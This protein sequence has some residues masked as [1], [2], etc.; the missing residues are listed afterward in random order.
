MR[1]A[2][3][4]VSSSGN[5]AYITALKIHQII[6]HDFEAS[7]KSYRYI[8][9]ILAI[10]GA[11]YQLFVTVEGSILLQLSKPEP[12]RWSV[13]KSKVHLRDLVYCSSLYADRARVFLILGKTDEEQ[14]HV[15]VVPEN[16]CAPEL[17][18]VPLT[19][20]E[21]RAILDRKWEKEYGRP[22]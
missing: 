3:I 22:L 20:A 13:A 2:S 21:A 5:F 14:M 8:E 18:S 16:D 17:K 10:D 19:W 15:L 1:Y 9:G 12:T 6:D 4:E 11:F 7:P